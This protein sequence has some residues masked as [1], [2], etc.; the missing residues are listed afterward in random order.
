MQQTLENL[1]KAGKEL[2]E[3]QEMVTS[4]RLSDEYMN[5]PPAGAPGIGLTMN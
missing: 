1:I 5:S 4:L 2:V 3:E